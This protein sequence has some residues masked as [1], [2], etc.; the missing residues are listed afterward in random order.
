M[1]IVIGPDTPSIAPELIKKVFAVDIP[2]FGHFL[3]DGFVDPQ[4]RRLAGMG[5]IVGK[6]VTVKAAAGDSTL[7][8][9]ATSKL[10]P[11]DVL[12][13]DTSGDTTHAALGGLLVSAVVA[14]GAVGVI[15]D[16]VC[17]DIAALEAA[18]IAVNA[19]ATT[20]LTNKLL[21]LNEGG[22]NVPV[23]CG[24]VTVNPGDLVLGDVNG[25][26]IASAA[27]IESV[28]DRAVESDLTEPA[29]INRIMNGELL[30]EL[31][32]AG[33]LLGNLGVVS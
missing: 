5:K 30:H 20:A 6:A 22:V 18:G 15:L 24:G 29:M 12:V 11:G 16:G 4:I 23:M 13:I 7:I 3:E 27:T 33:T 8:H 19:L 9:Y 31:S 17:T 26:L 28:V 32:R 10:T 1:S 14:S 2:T 21:G 25:V